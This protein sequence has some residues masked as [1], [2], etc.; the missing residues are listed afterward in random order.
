MPRLTLAI[1]ALSILSS[2]RWL[3]IG[4]FDLPRDDGDETRLQIS[5]PCPTSTPS[6]VHHFGL[7]NY[8]SSRKNS[9]PQQVTVDLFFFPLRRAH[10]SCS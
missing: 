9:I 10:L 6:W 7:C 3:V 8:P 2:E 4:V 1:Q 5:H